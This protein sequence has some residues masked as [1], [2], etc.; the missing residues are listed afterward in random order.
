MTGFEPIAVVGRGCVLP[1]AANPTELWKLVEEGRCVIDTPPEG[2]WGLDPKAVLAGSAAPFPERSATDKGG[3]VRGFDAIFDPSGFEHPA[4]VIRT[5][6]PATKWLLGSAR[7][8]LAECKMDTLPERTGLILGNLAYHTVGFSRYA[9][10][11]WLGQENKKEAHHRFAAGSLAHRVAT[12]LGVKG[13]FFALD[14][15]CASSLY[16]LHFACRQ[17]Q[18]GHAEIMLV[19]A[20]NHADDLFLHMGFTALQALSP[21][22]FSRPFH[23]EANGLI[24]AE[25]AAMVVLQRLS[26]AVAAGRPILGVIRHVGLSN[27]GRG[28]GLLAPDERGQIRAMQ[29]AYQATGIDPKRISLAECHATGTVLGDGVELASM[30][31]LFGPR[32]TP[33]VLGSLKANMGHLI[34]ASGM[35][36]LLKVLAAMAHGYFPPTPNTRPLSPAVEQGPFMVPE[37]PEPWESNDGP[38]LAVINNFGFGGNNAHLILEEWVPDSAPITPS[39]PSPAEPMP[40]IAVVGVGLAVGDRKNTAETARA[41]FEHRPTVSPARQAERTEHPLKGL[42]FPPDDLKQALPQQ[43]LL[44]QA[45]REA[46][47]SLSERNPDRTGLLVGMECDAESCRFDLRWRHPGAFGNTADSVV[48]ELT[49]AGVLGTMPNILANRLNSLLDLRGMGL[50]IAQGTEGGTVALRLAFA[51]LCRGDLDT[52][53]VGAVEMATNPVHEKAMA[54]HFPNLPQ[55]SGDAA[56][57]LTL[58]RLADAERDGDPIL[59]EITIGRF[60]SPDEV[61][62]IPWQREPV[63]A[64]FGF[65]YAADS[66]LHVALGVLSVS[67]QALP[68]QRDSGASPRFFPADDSGLLVTSTGGSEITL[69]SHMHALPRAVGPKPI[70]LHCYSGTDRDA[71]KMHLRQDNPSTEGP[72]KVVI[73]AKNPEMLEIRRK[74]ALNLLDGP[75]HA[76]RPVNL[77]NGIFLCDTPIDGEIAFMFTGVAAAY[78]GMGRE[79]LLALPSLWGKCMKRWVS[80]QEDTLELIYGGDDEWRKDPVGQLDATALI[81]QLHATLTMDLFGLAPTAALG[82]SLGESNALFAFGVWREASSMA[83]DLLSSEIYGRWLTGQCQAAARS[84]S[85]PDHETVRWKNWHILAPLEEVRK[86]VSEEPRVHITIIQSPSECVIGGEESA[87]ERVVRK[88]GLT[89]AQH[90]SP[91]MVNHCPEFLVIEDLWR[92]IHH[93]HTYP[94]PHVRFYRNDKGCAYYPDSD[95]A[96]DALTGQAGCTV[97]FPRTVRRAWEDG[98]RIFVEHGPGNSLTRS[99]GETLQG[100]PHLAIALDRRGACSLASAMDTAATLLAAGQPIDVAGINNAFA[101]INAWRLPEAEKI[102]MMEFP[103]RWPRVPTPRDASS[104]EPLSDEPKTH[105]LPDQPSSDMEMVQVP[106][107]PLAATAWETREEPHTEASTEIRQQLSPPVLA[108]VSAVLHG[109]TPGS[110]TLENETTTCDEST[111]RREPAPLTQPQPSSHPEPMAQPQ[112]PPATP[113]PATEPSP[114]PAA[115]DSLPSPWKNLMEETIQVHQEYVRHQGQ[116]RR[117]FLEN[118]AILLGLRPV[119][120]TDSGI[121][122]TP[123]APTHPPVSG[124]ASTPVETPA[125]SRTPLSVPSQPESSPQAGHPA[126]ETPPISGVEEPRIPPAVP[127]QPESSHPA[128]VEISTRTNVVFTRQDLEVLASGRISSIFGPLF[129]KQD[130]YARQV[131]MPEPPLLLADR[132]TE[133]RGEPGSLGLGSMITESDVRTDSWYLHQGTMPPGIMIESGQADL[134][135]ISW[136]GIDFIN[137]G[138]RVYRLLGCELTFHEGG[139]PRPG[140]TLSFDIRVDGHARQGDIRLF[141][142]HYDCRIDGKLRLSMRSGQAGFFNDAELADSGGVLWSAEEEQPATDFRMDP[143]P[144]LTTRRRFSAQEVGEFVRGNPRDCFGEEFRPASAHQRT[145]TI[146]KG[147]LQLLQEITA[148]E[149][150]GGPWGRGYLR[151]ETPVTS[152]DWY[153]QGHFKNDPC[154]PGTLMA[155]A[156]IQTMTFYMAALGFT[157]DRDGWRFEPV[158]NQPYTFICR[159]QVTPQSRYLTYELFVES[160]ED[161]PQPRLF[162]TVLCH[163]DG[164]KIFLCRYMGITLV[165]DWPLD[166]R[167][168]SLMNDPPHYV[169]SDERVRGDFA[170]LLACS[171]GAPSQAFGEMY[172]PLDGPHRIPRL[173]GPPYHLVTHI[174]SLST[175]SGIAERGG[176]LSTSYEIPPDA[177]YFQENSRQVMPFCVLMETMLQPCGWYASYMGFVNR[178]PENFS[179][180]NLDGKSVSLHREPTPDSGTLRVEVDF[181]DFSR[182]GSMVLVFFHVESFLGQEPVLSFDTSFGFFT[183]GALSDQK[184]L[185]TSQEEKALISAPSRFQVNLAKTPA[186]FFSGQ[187]RLPD[188]RLRMIDEITDFQPN[189]GKN[190]LG[191]L[192]TR[193]QVDPDAWYF[194]AHFFQDPVQPGSLGIEAMLQALQC[195]MLAKD[196]DK[197]IPNGHFRIVTPAITQEKP[198]IWKY[199]GQVLPTNREVVIGMH[200]THIERGEEGI[201][202]IGEGTLWVDGLCIYQLEDLGMRIVSAPDGASAHPEHTQQEAELPAE[203]ASGTKEAMGAD[204]ERVEPVGHA[205]PDKNTGGQWIFNRGN[206]P[207]LWDHCPTHTAAAMPM[208]GFMDLMAQAATEA[209]TRTGT[210]QPMVTEM[211]DARA[212]RWAYPDR[213]GNIVLSWEAKPIPPIPDHGDEQAILV[214]LRSGPDTVARSTVIL[215]GN[216]EAPPQFTDREIVG[217]NPQTVS[218]PYD[219]LFHGPAFQLL[220]SL[221]VGAHG[222]E[223]LLDAGHRKGMPV[224]LLHPTLLDGVTHAMPHDRLGIWFANAPRDQVAYPQHIPWLR[225]YGPTPTM[226]PVCCRVKASKL[227]NNTAHFLIQ[228]DDPQGSPWLAMELHESLL[229]MGRLLSMD[230]RARRPFLEERRFVPDVRLSLPLQKGA[231]LSQSDVIAANWFPG[232]LETVYNSWQSILELT[233]SIVVKECLSTQTALHPSVF[234]YDG[235]LVETPYLPFSRIHPVIEKAGDQVTVLDC[236]ETL[237]ISGP[238]SWWRNHLNRIGMRPL[239]DGSLEA[240]VFALIGRFVRRVVIAD[241]QG[242]AD[243]RGKSGVFLTD[244]PPGVASIL[245]NIL[246]SGLFERPLLM[247]TDSERQDARTGSFLSLLESWPGVHLPPLLTFSDSTKQGDAKGA[248]SAFLQKRLASATSALLIH[249][250]GQGDLIRVLAKSGAPIIP[251]R[252]SGE[253]SPDFIMRDYFIGA[254]VLPG[255]YPDEKPEEHLLAALRDPGTRISPPPLDEDLARQITEIAQ[256]HSLEPAAAAVLAALQADPQ[257]TSYAESLIQLLAGSQSQ[258][259]SSL[260][261]WFSGLVG[262]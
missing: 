204:P 66:L 7:Q 226:G 138:E 95:S 190:G 177:W 141:F 129:E 65:P 262:E 4:E 106:P 252:F 60:G 36:G 202:A 28:K 59:T 13:I 230:Y 233:E 101:E 124:E 8:A 148:F 43:L 96:A 146:P 183:T 14:A 18:E 166:E 167:Y 61:D 188:T 180:R 23:R 145:P 238:R 249:A 57:V 97:D 260:Q 186:R 191:F 163:C 251:V 39:I 142:F 237:D 254:P 56:A 105:K 154:M 131:R 229:P 128:P 64:R 31:T 199:R 33:L 194:K 17:L 227:E 53:L 134:L 108:S 15:A 115:D 169:G 54:D 160:V 127:T 172:R 243:C 49:S 62:L 147:P 88:I 20:A 79:L 116:A 118:Q 55:E 218:S 258:D 89:R 113:H 235:Q 104:H 228:L 19:G 162:G 137:R 126:P 151:A 25:G 240:L 140:D 152:N 40:K 84:W 242:F 37:N 107:P 35:A 170:A 58:K 11:V 143:P 214:V 220:T 103:A 159:G 248:F 221:K 206:A 161:G 100:K 149:P 203:S 10:S 135:L 200:L 250:T 239:D 5:M 85:L 87:C 117:R 110:E 1:G 77:G 82:V 257:T 109:R 70:F 168:P 236:S 26:E 173:P 123:P 121:K 102:G 78:G 12:A 210:G 90:L 139:L 111:I 83:E 67:G 114:D 24:P 144:C 261:T 16:A 213:H 119:P 120:T 171:W 212:F 231:T 179:F 98:V 136:L 41:L 6:D 259:K 52:A 156:A 193:Q 224:G 197:E 207:W 47:S 73:Q 187:A 223:A 80:P 86:Q 195:L 198:M 153:F 192:R 94:V 44:M 256:T 21:T 201:L 189:G 132:V 91:D 247:V 155:D 99:V 245:F 209:V 75:E 208:M 74:M 178:D 72:C 164:L 92:R 176:H 27:D 174:E 3:Y 122:T 182:T 219:H 216:P 30:T 9:E 157:I 29:A 63:T 50:T 232:T 69:S 234:Q 175:P 48:P 76:A 184:G 34:T 196:L 68:G 125:K 130:Q 185:A 112:S 46:I 205:D 181:T 42:G 165:P 215:N 150:E 217:E 38:R 246:A 51:A 241:P 133:I 253:P 225:I 211:R 32:E 93:R 222:A 158:T 81:C 45:A 22:G 71:V 244:H 2:H 255:Q